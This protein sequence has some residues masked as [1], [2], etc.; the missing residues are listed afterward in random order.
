[1]V[2][3]P[4]IAPFRLLGTTACYA[5]AKP[6]DRVDLEDRR[7]TDFSPDRNADLSAA[8]KAIPEGRDMH[9]P[10]RLYS[11][12]HDEKA[13]THTFCLLAVDDIEATRQERRGDSSVVAGRHLR[14]DH[15]QRQ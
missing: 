1:M 10:I 4:L 7:P 12:K 13:F 11:R 6:A 3:P 2:L 8:R 5:E 15:D 9:K 14:N